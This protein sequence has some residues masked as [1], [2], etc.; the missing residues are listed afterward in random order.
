LK[1]GHIYG[2]LGKDG[3]GKTTLIKN[4]TGLAFPEKGTC[5]I[6]DLAS[7]KRSPD[8]LEDF[9]LIPEEIY[10]P[11]TSIRK[12]LSNTAGFYPKFDK[13]QCLQYLNE[14]ELNLD[15]NIS[16][17]SFGQQKKVIIAFAL[18]TNTDVIIMDEPTNGLDIPS[19]VQ[20]R[21][22]V[23]AVLTEDR[24]VLISTHQVRD[25]ENLID[26]LI[27]LDDR[28]IILNASIDVIAEKLLFSTLS[29]L[30]NQNVLHSESTIKGYSV[31]T[32]NTS[33]KSSKV[34]LELLFNGL[35]DDKNEIAHELN[36]AIYE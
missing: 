19:K 16:N 35:M 3:A 12:F 18:A 36:L 23:S 5:T 26:V 33:G 15:N 32:P 22:I 21:K 1:P 27:V 2:L 9:F 29:T 31:I 24:C 14:F 10:L 20:F 25:L 13:N 34:D 30:E 8:L 6:N 11:A 7:S 4:I 28:R 17:L